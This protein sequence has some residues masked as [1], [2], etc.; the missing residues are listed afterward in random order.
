MADSVLN[1]RAVARKLETK[2]G[3]NPLVFPV[4]YLHSN[5]IPSEDLGGTKATVLADAL[6]LHVGRGVAEIIILP[7]FFARGAVFDR[8]VEVVAQ[9]TRGHRVVVRYAPALVDLEEGNRIDTRVASIIAKRVAAAT[10]AAA[11]AATAAATA[12]T[13]AAAAAAVATAAA[14]VVESTSL[15][16]GRRRRPRVVLLDHGSP[17][18]AMTHLRNH[19]AG[20]LAMLL[21]MQGLEVS[22]CVGASME[23]RPGDEFEFGEPLLENLLSREPYNEGPVVVAM[24]FLSPGRH[25]GSGGDVEKICR[26]AEEVSP[27][28]R[29]YVTELVGTHDD[30]VDIL[31]GNL[32]T[33]TL[34]PQEPG[35]IPF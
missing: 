17:L 20:Q 11:A 21:S 18:P 10:A 1:L 4:S 8:I 28:L 34:T 33:L 12:T 23:R 5:R 9:A 6:T 14:V 32:A 27:R 25:A 2:L 3:G 15:Q 29:C 31:V 26:K 16:S 35:I 30:V 19:V 13:A 24:M 22:G 7:F